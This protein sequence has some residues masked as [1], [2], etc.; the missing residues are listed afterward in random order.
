MKR[1]AQQ[2]VLVLDF[3]SQ[4]AQLIARPVREQQVYCE[5]VNHQISADRVRE[6]EPTGLIFSPFIFRGRRHFR[7]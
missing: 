5:I 4:Y 3:G 7:N 2:K 1:I 6:L